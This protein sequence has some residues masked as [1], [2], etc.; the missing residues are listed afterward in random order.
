MIICK[1]WEST[2]SRKLAASVHDVNLGEAKGLE[3][4]IHRSPSS[5]G[6]ETL[7][8]SKGK[9]PEVFLRGCG[10][11]DELIVQLPAIIASM[12]PIQF[13]SCFISYSSYDNP[14]ARRLY[15][16][17]EHFSLI[18]SGFSDDSFARMA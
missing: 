15:A 16:R 6:A 11:P 1:N 4:V 12:E 17:L 8:A 10:V 7:L 5:I 3:D 2:T 13:Y 18:C 9:I 14:F